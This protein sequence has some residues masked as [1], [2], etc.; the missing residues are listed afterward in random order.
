MTVLD[1]LRQTALED[2]RLGQVIRHAVPRTLT[3]G[4]GACHMALTGSRSAL[5]SSATLARELSYVGR[6][7]D[8]LLALQL[9]F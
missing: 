6:P 4:D 8:H 7:L 9:R 1:T 3:G 2:C 5:H